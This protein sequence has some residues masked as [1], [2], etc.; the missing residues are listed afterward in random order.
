LGGVAVENLQPTPDVFRKIAL[1]TL[2]GFLV[3]V[4][5][6]PLLAVLSFAFVILSFTIIGFMVWLPL[7]VLFAGKQTAWQDVR[8]MGV[9]LRT[10]ASKWGR[11]VV[12]VLGFP[13]RIVRGLGPGVLHLVRIALRTALNLLR[14]GGEIA[15]MGVGGAMVGV[16]WG[17]FQ[18][19]PRPL[20]GAIAMNALVAGSLAALAGATMAL[21]PKKGRA[22]QTSEV[23]S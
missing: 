2:V 6:G 13:L 20:A 9:A 14:V 17:A 15:L 18:S 19:G 12:Q 7:R 1:F 5:M 22:P 10:D 8:N 23:L 4:L 16:L 3:V 21:L 11:R